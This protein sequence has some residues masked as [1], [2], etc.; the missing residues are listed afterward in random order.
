MFYSILYKN[1]CL[2]ASDFLHMFIHSIKFYTFYYYVYQGSLS[3]IAE[4]YVTYLG[5]TEYRC[6]KNVIHQ[7][8]SKIEWLL[9]S[10]SFTAKFRSLFLREFILKPTERA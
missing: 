10:A 1:D 5:I 9:L 8:D 2:A 3:S 7:T 4:Y 6:L